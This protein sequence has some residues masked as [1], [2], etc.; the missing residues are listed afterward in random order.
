METVHW[1]RRIIL[2]MDDISLSLARS[3]YEIGMKWS[4]KRVIF[5]C[6]RITYTTIRR[7]FGF[8]KNKQKINQKKQWKKMF[9]DWFFCFVSIFFL[10]ETDMVFCF[11][12]QKKIKTKFELKIY[13]ICLLVCVWVLIDWIFKVNFVFFKLRKNSLC[14]HKMIL[15]IQLSDRHTQGQNNEKLNE[16]LMFIRRGKKNKRRRKKNVDTFFFWF[17]SEKIDDWWLIVFFFVPI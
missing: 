6:R 10:F 11:S 9:F 13:C 4:E 17:R 14:K 8:F 12:F 15:Q 1:I 16:R 3:L 2:Q 5:F 7:C